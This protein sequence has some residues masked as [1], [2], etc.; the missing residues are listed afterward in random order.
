MDAMTKAVKASPDFK[1][2]FLNQTGARA[3]TAMDNYSKEKWYTDYTQAYKQNFMPIVQG[4]FGAG[5]VLS[6]KDLVVIAEGLGESFIPRSAK[7]NALNE[8]KTKGAAK[9][10]AWLSATGANEE[11]FTKVYPEAANFFLGGDSQSKSPDATTNGIKV[12]TEDGGYVYK[13]GD[14]SK[15]ESWEKK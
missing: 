1:E 12:G 10:R 7:Q 5:K 3:E 15:P 6:D 11:S 9:I 4:L 13:G 14:P 8:L 2:G